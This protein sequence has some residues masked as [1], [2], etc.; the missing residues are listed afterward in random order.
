MAPKNNAVQ[1]KIAV[2]CKDYDAFSKFMKTYQ[3][4]MYSKARAKFWTNKGATEYFMMAEEL[5]HGFPINGIIMLE[6]CADKF[7]VYMAA[8]GMVA[9]GQITE[10]EL[11]R[12]QE[13][14]DIINVAP[15]EVVHEGEKND[16]T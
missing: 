11:E 10:A 3:I 9:L 15:E 13:I 1:N 6:G 14:H 4:S 12:E 16:Q 5:I 7:N 8:T 2:I